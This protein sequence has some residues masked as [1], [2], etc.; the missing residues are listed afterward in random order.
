[1]NISIY[2]YNV[3]LFL[4]V[5]VCGLFSSIV[6]VER[7]ACVLLTGFHLVPNPFLPSH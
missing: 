7:S 4:F 2:I 5:I 3:F 1:M 6:L